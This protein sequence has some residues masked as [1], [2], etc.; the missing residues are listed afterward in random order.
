MARPL[1][2][3]VG[4]AIR[5]RTVGLLGDVSGTPILFYALDIY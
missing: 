2:N 3:I 1:N 4:F 5:V